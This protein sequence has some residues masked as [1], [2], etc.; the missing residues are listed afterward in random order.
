M[1]KQKV[2][3]WLKEKLRTKFS[4]LTPKNPDFGDYAVHTKQIKDQRS[5]TKDLTNDE[6]FEKVEEKDGFVNF[7]INDKALFEE[8][9]EILSQ[10]DDYGKLDLLKNQKIM[11]EF[12]HP[13]THKLFHIGH[14]RNIILG[15]AFARILHFAGAEIIRANYQGDV[16][17][18]IAKCLWTMQKSK[19]KDQN[20]ELKSQNLNVKVQFLGQ[21]Y[22]KGNQAYETDEQA[23]KEIQ[24]INRQLFAKDE[25]IKSLWQVTRQ[26]SLDYF[27]SI[28]KRLGVKFDRFYFESEVADYG[29]KLSQDALAKNILQAS[30]G[31]VIFNGKKHG[32]DTR[33]FINSQ[34]L[35]TYEAKELGLAKLEFTEFGSLDR[36][37]HVVAAEQTSFFKTVFLVETLLDAS[38]YKNKQYHFVYGMVRLKSGKMSSRGGTVIEGPRL[39]DEVK[40]RLKQTFACSDEIAKILTVG[41]VKYAFLKIDP[42]KDLVFDIDESISLKGNSGVYILYTYAR[43]QSV[44]IKS[45]VKSPKLKVNL[46]IDLAPEERFLLRLFF[47]FPEVVET[48][49]DQYFPHLLAAYAFDLAQ[50][51][52]LFY[53]KLPILKAGKESRLLRLAITEATGLSLKFTLNLLGI[54]T[55][56][57]I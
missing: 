50:R 27:D 19:I 2:N 43:I 40:N 25:R 55:V 12:A 8:L 9:D 14:L 52:N 11:V 29:L 48:A 1:I 33:V 20:D 4:L 13:N 56:E 31:A 23:K 41:A 6:L 37:I 5:K 34:G 39:M 7:F 22:V 10:R 28:Y 45:K 36:C 30:E 16:G 49:V 15:E 57:K 53:E 42:K 24:E 32:V 21:A 3:Q 54:A 18:H 51:F 44:I 46:K 35:P 38:L 26:W 47:R 17:L